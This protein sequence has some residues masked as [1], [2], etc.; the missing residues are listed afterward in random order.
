MTQCV[1]VDPNCF[2]GRMLY[3]DVCVGNDCNKWG[4]GLRL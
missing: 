3:K 4:S 1:L 2:H